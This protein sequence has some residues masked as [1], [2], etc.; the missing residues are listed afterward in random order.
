MFLNICDLLG[1]YEL[2]QATLSTFPIKIL[3]RIQIRILSGAYPSIKFFLTFP[4]RIPNGKADNI[5][6]RSSR[7]PIRIHVEILVRKALFLFCSY[8][9]VFQVANL[10]SDGFIVFSI[11][12]L[13]ANLQ[14]WHTLSIL[15]GIIYEWRSRGMIP[16][17][18]ASFAAQTRLAEILNCSL[19]F[20]TH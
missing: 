8:L 12:V 20:V 7:F 11:P 9:T 4:F 2:Y 3:T 19:E 16:F 5:I 14:Q 10:C 13:A 1:M 6:H 18:P 17:D 15:L